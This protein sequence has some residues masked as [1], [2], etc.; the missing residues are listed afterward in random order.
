MKKEEGVF[1]ILQFTVTRLFV[2]TGALVD[3]VTK[4][5]EETR[6]TARMAH[7]RGLIAYILI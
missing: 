3:I 1:F 5:S 2:C 4:G 7:T 6:A